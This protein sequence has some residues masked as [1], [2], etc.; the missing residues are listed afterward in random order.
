[1][2]QWQHYYRF[3]YLPLVLPVQHCSSIVYQN[4]SHAG[5]PIIIL[6]V[7]E[8]VASF[9]PYGGVLM[10]IIVIANTIGWSHLYHW[11]DGSLVDPNSPHFDVILYEKSKYLNIPFYLVRT[12]IFVG[13]ATFFVFKLKSL[14]KASR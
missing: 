14:S 2:N 4:A 9:I 3:L 5:W 7:M 12:L 1:M 10:L 11:M 13:G 6:R 8:A